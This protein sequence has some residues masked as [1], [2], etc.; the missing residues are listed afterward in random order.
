MNLAARFEILDGNRVSQ[1]ERYRT[2]AENTIPSLLPRE[3]H[4][5]TEEFNHPFSSVQARG[6]TGMAS[7]MLG[8]MLPL[9]D[10]PFFQLGLKSGRDQTVEEREYL[11]D[12]ARRAH[13]KLTSKNL[14]DSLFQ[15]LKYLITVG[16]CMV[17]LED[18]FKIRL[19]RLDHYVTVRN[20]LGDVIEIIYLDFKFRDET[21]DPVTLGLGGFSSRNTYPFDVFYN[22]IK[23]NEKT[24]VWDF[25]RENSKGDLLET[26]TYE[27][28]ALPFVAARWNVVPG[29]HYGRSYVEEIYGDIISLE[30]Y[31]ESLTETLSASASWW[32]AVNPYGTTDLNDV[33]GRPNGSW[34]AASPNDVFVISP[35]NTMRSSVQAAFEAVESMRRSVSTA[36]LDSQGQVRQAERVTAAEIRMLGQELEQVLGGAFSAIAKELFVP[37]VRR[38]LFLMIENG[39]LDERITSTLFDDD[40]GIFEIDIITGLQALS[41]DND[42]V[43]LMQMGDMMR[44]L[45]PEAAQSF[46]WD[47]YGRALVTALGFNP[48]N[49]IKSPEEVQQEQSMQ[50]GQQMAA[51]GMGAGIEQAAMGAAQQLVGPM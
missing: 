42:L 44:N 34:I 24:Q 14:R 19:T 2:F 9:N 32:P 5:Q 4:D 17:T 10:M 28:F 16:N 37:L 48:T 22:Q 50:M 6:I 46:K 15:A 3:G 40:D 39:E 45:P 26:G 8:A 36:F 35:A 31:T 7:K 13:K 51:Q 12:I 38:T 20:I 27:K 18:D 21:A 33:S 30:A 11:E 25:R 43:K 49:W 47:E 1:L 29:E 41:R 23:W